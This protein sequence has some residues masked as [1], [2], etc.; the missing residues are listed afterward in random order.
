[1]TAIQDPKPVAQ[2]LV[3]S[4]GLAKQL[5]TVAGVLSDTLTY[6]Q[7][8]AQD[9][10]EGEGELPPGL[11]G[12][13]QV[14]EDTIIEATTEGIRYRVA[15]SDATDHHL[16][17]SG[18]VKLYVLP[19]PSGF[20]AIAFGADPTG[21]VD[22]TSA[23]QDFFDYIAVNNVGTARIDGTFL[24]SSPL[25]FGNEDVLSSTLKVTGRCVLTATA[26]IAG[27]LLTIKGFNPGEWDSLRINGTGGTSF[28]SRTCEVGLR[29]VNSGRSSFGRLRIA[30]FQFAGL[31]VVGGN[32]SFAAMGG[33]K[34]SDCGSG[35]D[36]VSLESTWDTKVNS[37]SSGS[38]SQRSTITVATL[39]PSYIL[40]E[41]YGDVDDI[42]LMVRIAGR[43]H[44][45]RAIDTDNSTL[46]VFPWIA[47]TETEGELEYVFGGGVF[48]RGSDVNVFD[49]AMIDATRC[50]I[51][52]AA[53]S[54]YGPNA[55]RIAT[56]S[57]GI[58]VA[59]GR[60]LTGASL[61]GVYSNMYFENNE[62]DIILIMR[63]GQ[64]AYNY[65]MSEYAINLDKCY[66]LA[67]PRLSDDQ[68]FQTFEGWQYQILMSSGD[69]FQYEKFSRNYVASST[70]IEPTR[71]DQ[72]LMHFQT[73]PVF[74]L[75]ALN[76]SVNRLTGVDSTRLVCLGSGTRNQPTG[77]VT[78][79]APDGWT[80]NGG[81]SAVFSGF[82]NPPEFAI[83]WQ[84][85]TS[86]IIV[87]RLN[88]DVEYVE[89]LPVSATNGD[90]ARFNPISVQDGGPMTYVATVTSG[91]NPL[92]KMVEQKGVKKDV[93]NNRPTGLGTTDV[94]LQFIE[95]NIGPMIWN[96]SSFVDYLQRLVS[97]SSYLLSASASYAT[98]T[99]ATSGSITKLSVF[100]WVKFTAA[101]SVTILGEWNSTTNNRSW[102][103]SPG[104]GKLR[105]LASSAGT[106]TNATVTGTATINDG[107]WHLVGATYD[108]AT[109]TVVLYV[110]DA[111]DTIASTVGT[112]PASIF[113]GAEGLTIGAANASS[114]PSS[115]F[116][117][118][119][120]RVAIYSEVL[121]LGDVQNMYAN[122]IIEDDLLRY[123]PMQETSGSVGY[124]TV[125]NSGHLTLVSM[126]HQA[127]APNDYAWGNYYGYRKSGSVII[128]GL[129]D[130]LTVADGNAFTVGPG[131]L[132]S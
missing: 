39:P 72:T 73:S 101:G 68:F 3:A 117:G 93:W 97:A 35:V 126:A 50:G 37:G 36:A 17:T 115:F 47:S 23:L 122:E 67:A 38:A 60:T 6:A 110:D 118:S 108:G 71:R 26:P 43:L 76:D 28:A 14:V 45:I 111:V 131:E 88:K 16:T 59:V 130:G 1:M 104:G 33:V 132:L 42:P 79:N 119:L 58:G 127:D 95:N 100:A 123:Y 12:S 65:F 85:T 83:F 56:Q 25:T 4:L 48:L 44:Y 34:V 109:Q 89:T 75:R 41:T 53:A 112:I 27:A 22:A 96:G 82:V 114:T 129:L 8:I 62:E 24:V 20:D 120:Q 102:M 66:C 125:A 121:P 99:K 52:L 98:A 81:S 30:N 87:E 57:C 78:F 74:S 13:N 70:A 90:V 19:G 69:I 9:A 11:V 92:W 128:P 86:N 18:G 91:S 63:S 124:N 5:P 77:T 40:S 21:T 15:A 103:L 84:V 107:N 116:N 113:N 64:S 51:G 80:V 106:S 31:V 32:S 46:E 49:F 29:M 2:R 61:G 55:R 94:G 10:I 54:L 7:P 105:F